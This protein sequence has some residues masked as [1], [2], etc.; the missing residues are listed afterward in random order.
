MTRP[1]SGGGAAEPSRS[2]SSTSPASAP[3]TADTG[4]AAADDAPASSP[5]A[6][7]LLCSWS[8]RET[9]LVLLITLLVT[10]A[11]FVLAVARA[12][13]SGWT[14]SGDQAM[15]ILR[16]HDVGTSRTPL[17][18]PYSR[19]G[20]DHPG[21]LLFWI[22]A[23]VLRLAGPVGVMVLVGAINIAATVTAVA[24][25]RRLAGDVF[26]LLVTA[27]VAVMVQSHGAVKLVDPWNPWV[28]ILPLLCYLLCVPTAVVHRSR[29]A[30][31][32][33]VVTG[34]FVAQSHLGN[35]PVVVAAALV[36]TA[37][38]R[39]DRAT[40]RPTASPTHPTGRSNWWLLILLGALWSGPVVDMVVNVPGNVGALAEFALG[41]DQ[42]P[43]PLSESLGAA[44]REV[45]FV[46][47]WLG[48][49]EGVWPVEPAPKWTLLVLPAALASGLVIRRRTDPSL[50][51]HAVALVGYALAICGAAVFAVTRTT[52]GLI[53]Y[54]LRWTWP[55]AMVATLV[56]LL[57]VVHAAASLRPGRRAAAIGSVAIATF[58]VSVL[59]TTGAIRHSID[60]PIEPSPQTDRSVGPLSK[61]IRDVLPKGDFGLEWVDVRS[62]SATSIG[63]GVD[64]TRHGYGI[65]FP[66]DHASRVGGFRATRRT[67]VPLL[68]IVGKTPAKDFVPADGAELIVEWDHLSPA[69]RERADGLDARIRTTAHV[70][71]STLVGVDN[72]KARDD[73]VA[74]GADPDAVEALYELEGDREGYEVWLAPPG[75]PRS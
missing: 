53:P 6:A 34:S 38:W 40:D 39:W 31:V 28:T 16:M 43:S 13:V 20:W 52:G 10:L 18:G 1:T 22:G 59:G 3:T 58:A 36:G 24:A 65:D 33:A 72:R 48:A 60:V 44:A 75:T 61:A 4:S 57:P 11:P 69:D 42:A 37:W 30:L 64:L 41:S 56:A 21:P 23:P 45:G 50:S 47:A 73:L 7:P 68:I 12:A 27:A 71:D 51:I 70:A 35:V 49:D 55:V 17:L 9:T 25:A 14:P 5:S 54:V 74:A 63:A 66:F 29:W 15:E 8:S 26:A 32:A 67:D 2:E 19:F 62:F 46:P